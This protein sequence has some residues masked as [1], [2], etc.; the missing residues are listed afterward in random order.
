M[1]WAPQQKAAVSGPSHHAVPPGRRW[2]IQDLGG[3]RAPALGLRCQW[4]LCRPP[5][6]HAGDK[7]RPAAP[8]LTPHHRRAASLRC[9]FSICHSI[10]ALD[11]TM[12]LLRRAGAAGLLL[13]LLAALLLPAGA[14]R[15]HLHT[16]KVKQLKGARPAG[17]RR[18]Q[19]G[20][21]L[22]ASA[23]PLTQPPP[24]RR[25]G[26]ARHC[27]QAEHAQSA[28]VSSRTARRAVGGAA[29]RLPPCGGG[30]GTARARPAPTPARS[31]TQVPES[32]D[33]LR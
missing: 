11:H 5:R 21:P 18:V 27:R 25:Q 23:R 4:R 13:P 29:R 15:M 12:R 33:G 32:E 28:Q 14:V 6:V 9:C 7:G 26:R 30:G 20:Q 10:H 24:P 19:R 8:Q 2:S 22:R 17:G 31:Y 3:C 1:H 16:P